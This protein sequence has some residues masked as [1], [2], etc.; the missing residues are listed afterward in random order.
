[1]LA[2]DWWLKVT[3]ATAII[4]NAATKIL[5]SDGLFINGRHQILTFD[6]L[7]I[8]AQNVTA[9]FSVPSDWLMSP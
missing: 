9:F 8:K 7:F 4:Y 5:S 1:M 3:S 6:W 2:S